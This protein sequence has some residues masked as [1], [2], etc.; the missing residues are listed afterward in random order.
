MNPP[1]VTASLR[2][3]P[4]QPTGSRA[5]VVDSYLPAVIAAVGSDCDCTVQ[6]AVAPRAFRHSGLIEYCDDTVT[7]YQ[8]RDP[9]VTRHRQDTAHNYESKNPKRVAVN[10]APRAFFADQFHSH[11][12]VTP[13]ISSFERNKADQLRQRPSNILQ[14]APVCPTHDALVTFSVYGCTAF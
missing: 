12:T 7:S 11:H 1:T 13:A 5:W 6:W 2:S 8:H 4:S 14:S 10:S 3:S 9:Q